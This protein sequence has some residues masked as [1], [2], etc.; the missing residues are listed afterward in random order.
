MLEG[1]CQDAVF[2]SERLRRRDISKSV[3]YVRGLCG[4]AAV[5]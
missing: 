2:V 1:G 5:Q 3:C 4:E